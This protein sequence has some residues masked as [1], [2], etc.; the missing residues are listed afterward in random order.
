MIC[1]SGIGVNVNRSILKFCNINNDH[2]HLKLH[3]LFLNV[4]AKGQLR[5]DNPETYVT[6]GHDTE[7]IKRNQNHNAE[8]KNAQQENATALLPQNRNN[9]K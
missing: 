9:K 1:L 3:D 4:I 5:I 7:R 6:I 2:Y 8:N